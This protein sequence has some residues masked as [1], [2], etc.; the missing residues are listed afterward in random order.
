MSSGKFETGISTVT[1]LYYY[2]VS[3]AEDSDSGSCNTIVVKGRKS[4]FLSMCH[5]TYYQS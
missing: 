4:Q 5:Q 1:H 3:T 2:S